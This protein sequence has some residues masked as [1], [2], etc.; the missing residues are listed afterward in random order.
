MTFMPDNKGSHIRS[1]AMKNLFV[2]I[3]L[4]ST[5]ALGVAVAQPNADELAAAT[6]MPPHSRQ[7]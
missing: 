3:I 6:Q 5:A 4:I 1:I 2:W 7:A